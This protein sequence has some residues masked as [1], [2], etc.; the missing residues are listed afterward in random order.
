M[1]DMEQWTMEYRFGMAV[2]DRAKVPDAVFVE[3]L[4]SKLDPGSR[5]TIG[6][7]MRQIIK[8]GKWP[9]YYPDYSPQPLPW[10]V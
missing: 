5:E 9:K 6:K 3:L 8:A 7:A 4:Y 2:L 1:T 10:E